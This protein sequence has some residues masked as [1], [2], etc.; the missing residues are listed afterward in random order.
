MQLVEVTDRAAWDEF[1]DSQP[2][3]HPLQLWGWGEAKRENNWTPYRLAL[4]DDERWVAAVQVL[5]WPIPRLGRRIA[6]VPRGPVVDPA[7]PNAQRL[8]DAL[9]S[10]TKQQKALYVRI[11]PAWLKANLP[12]GWARSRHHLQMDE[13]YTIDLEKSEEQLLESMIR[14]HRQYIRKAERDGV[15]VERLAA[16]DLAPMYEIYSQ[17]AMRAGFGIHTEDYYA[18]LWEAL[19][20]HNFL[21]YA[22]FEGRPVAFLWLVAAG[23]TAYELYGGV[24]A[25][26]QELKAN[27]AL[28]WRAI[29]EMKR[30]GKRIYDFNGRVSEGVS[31]FKVGFGPD[32]T[33]YAGTWDYPLNRAGYAL[34]E[35]VWPMAKPIGRLMVRRKKR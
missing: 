16:K 33:D 7:S 11:E 30:L 34:W 5:L 13:T 3:G 25:E 9:V 1:V 23:E 24:N 8:L 19:G 18:G 21:Y 32:T 15:T 17:T 31:Q 28:K 4:V 12:K 35:K 2:Y 20:Q 22:R 10:W 27:Y 26:G 29:T 6:Y 14:K